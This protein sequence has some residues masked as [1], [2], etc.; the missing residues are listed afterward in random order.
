MLI[1]FMRWIP[2]IHYGVKTGHNLL[3][4]VRAINSKDLTFC[5][6][7]M[8]NLGWKNICLTGLLAAI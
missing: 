2:V 5:T 8:F 6:D 3:D 7:G 1:T 4:V